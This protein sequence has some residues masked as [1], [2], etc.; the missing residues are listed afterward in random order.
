MFEN[1]IEAIKKS[2]EGD[3]E[4]LQKLIEKN[5]GLICLKIV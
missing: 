1:S 3:K 4:E 2:Q 5:N